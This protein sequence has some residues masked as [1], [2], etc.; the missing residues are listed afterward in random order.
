VLSLRSEKLEIETALTKEEL[1]FNTEKR[2]PLEQRKD[3][4]EGELLKA[5]MSPIVELFE[6][7]VRKNCLL[8]LSFFLVNII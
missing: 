8:K 6:K 1:R 5:K 4:I 2:S 7:L 3:E